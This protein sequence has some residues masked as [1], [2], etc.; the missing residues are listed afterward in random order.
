MEN[1]L[2]FAGNYTVATRL[3]ALSREVLSGGP[4]K[5][6][7]NSCSVCQCVRQ[8][9]QRRLQ[10]FHA[11]GK[12]ETQITRRTK[13]GSGHQR[14]PRLV[15]QVFGEFDVIRYAIQAVDDRL[16]IRDTLEGAVRRQ[17]D[18]AG[19]PVQC[20][21]HEIVALPESFQHGLNAR[22]VAIECGLRGYL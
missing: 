12:G 5:R 9:L 16:D 15:Q 17:T 11:G 1:I 21:H 8:A 3:Y 20:L 6:C 10:C 7:R 18:D 13:R 19:D 22:L 4:D 2:R 14:H